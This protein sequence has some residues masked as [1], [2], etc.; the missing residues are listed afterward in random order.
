MNYNIDTI[1]ILIA[2]FLTFTKYYVPFQVFYDIVRI[3]I[4][5]ESLNDPND[6][7]TGEGWCRYLNPLVIIT[8]KLDGKCLVG[9]NERNNHVVCIDSSEKIYDFVGRGFLLEEF[10][11]IFFQKGR[12]SRIEIINIDNANVVFLYYKY[13]TK[14]EKYYHINENINNLFVEGKTD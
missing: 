14:M 11:T 4:N 1:G 6:D 7:F 3:K 5:S 2:F 9:K 8:K 13:L 12:P 10:G